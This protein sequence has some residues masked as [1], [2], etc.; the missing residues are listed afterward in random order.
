[1][2][3][4]DL[5]QRFVGEI[6]ELPGDQHHPFIQFAHMLCGLGSDQPDEVPWCSSFINAVCWLLRLPRSKSARARSW[7]EVGRAIELRDAIP[8]AD[9]VVLKRGSSA[10]AGHV[11]FFA[12][13][14]QMTGTV[15][16]LGGNQ[17]NGVTVAPFKEVDVLGVRRLAA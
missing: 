5:A 11:G 7:L 9:I 6:R 3:P 16:V 13:R 15:Y 2:T 1:M 10:T 12:G 4:F 14:D 17:S 8:N